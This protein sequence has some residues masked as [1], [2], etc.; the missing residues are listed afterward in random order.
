MLGHYLTVGMRSLRRAPI[1]TAVNLLALA[2][3]LAAFVAAHG[4]VSYWDQSE[5][6]FANS[7]RTYVVTV[8]FEGR[9]QRAGR[10]PTP[11]TNRLFAD[12][13]RSDM[14]ELEAVAR[15]QGMGNET[16]VTAG[17]VKTRMFIVGAES[18]F[19]EIFDLPFI[20]GDPKN[21]LRDPNSV[22]LT[23]DAATSLF[24]T[25][26]AIGRTVT[27]STLLDA[28]VT[29]VIDAIPEPSH[30]GRT[31]SGGLRFD[32][33]AS[34]DMIDGI[35]A[36][37]RA[38]DPQSAPPQ[39]PPNAPENWLGGYCCTT[40]LMPRRDSGFT[41]ES[42]DAALREFADRHVPVAQKELTTLRAGAVP[43]RNLMVSQLNAQLLPGAGISITTLLLGLGAIVLVVACVNYANLATAQATRRAREIGLRKSLGAAKHKVML[44]YLA[45]AGLLTAAAA[46]L[47]LVIVRLVTP[48]LHASLGIDLARGLYGPE[49]W[50]FLAAALVGVTLLA[51]AYP[52]F[53][54]ARVA[55]IEALRAGGAKLGPRFASTLLVGVQFAAAS[56]LM[57]LVTVMYAQNDALRRSALGTGEDQVIVLPI[58][59]QL[60]RAD[61]ALFVEEVR[62]LPQVVNVT[63]TQFPP[64]APFVSLMPIARTSDDSTVPASVFLNSV[65]FDFFPTIGSD[66]LAGRVQDREHGDDTLSGPLNGAQTVNIVIDESLSRQLG[67]DSPQAAV[68]QIVYIP[69]SAMRA[70]AGA[71]AAAQPFRVIGVVADR[72]LH[73][74]GAGATANMYWV[75]PNL[76]VVLARIAA[77][78]VAGGLAAIDAIW[79]RLSPNASINR[80]FMDELFDSSYANFERI[81]QAFAGLAFVAVAIS[82]IGLFGMAAQVA[83]RRIHEI[84]V[85]KSVGARTGQIVSMLLAQFSRPVWIANVVAWPIAYF[86]AQRYLAAF[87]HRIDITAYPFVAS[88]LVTLAVAF[89]A[90]GGQALRAAR[91]NPATVL[92]AE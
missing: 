24:G 85:R 70:F 15:A 84:G 90:V 16:A 10:A 2:L 33:L 31:A 55:P 60:T 67:F 28:T 25:T 57:V 17:D 29:G 6:H 58:Y 71:A 22:V 49:F 26:D 88:L 56:F 8:L 46:A 73:L 5:R 80:H 11:T 53:L 34:W 54:L 50:A 30:F 43:L 40:Y 64:W 41:D 44:Q 74:R 19:L 62:R 27:L 32:V 52:A 3:G 18:S 7:D 20:A 21:A 51:A 66:L 42:L 77:G 69:D 37:A 82:V 75:Q 87:I 12:Y 4:V 39:P 76:P 92:R 91:T 38:R 72:P 79:N 61:G 14:P 89:V 9:N 65:G 78:D 83:G 59:S 35:Q 68:E 47:A 1:T 45:E 86:A 63:Q 13:L 81:N 48:A 23:R 36:A